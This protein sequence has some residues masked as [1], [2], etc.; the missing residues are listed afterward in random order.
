MR[1]RH[2]AFSSF[3]LDTTRS[4]PPINYEIITL[5]DYYIVVQNEFQT[6]SSTAGACHKYLVLCFIAPN[7][8]YFH[9]RHWN[10]SPLWCYFKDAFHCLFNILHKINLWVLFSIHE[11]DLWHLRIWQCLNC[12]DH[13][14]N[15]HSH[16]VYALHKTMSYLNISLRTTTL[17]ILDNIVH[18]S[19]S[20][21]VHIAWRQNII[22]SM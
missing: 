15:I 12:S 18:P 16:L 7:V 8:R 10:I 6:S 4:I 21:D 5:F 22:A 14:N 2:S 11:L 19:F 20:I 17:S 9:L 13:G 1:L 3:R